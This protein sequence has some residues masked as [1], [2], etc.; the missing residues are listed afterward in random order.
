LMASFII[1]ARRQSPCHQHMTLD[2][3]H[4]QHG[5]HDM[6]YRKSDLALFRVPVGLRPYYLVSF[7]SRRVAKRATLAKQSGR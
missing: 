2:I 6:S 4:R 1:I 5:H 3:V 7:D